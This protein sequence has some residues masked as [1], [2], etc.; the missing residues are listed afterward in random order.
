ML[1]EARREPSERAAL[2]F[3]Q[4]CGAGCFGHDRMLRRLGVLSW[5]ENEGFRPKTCHDRTLKPCTILSWQ[6]WGS[7]VR[8][9]RRRLRVFSRA[10]AR[11]NKRV[12]PPRPRKTPRRRAGRAASRPQNDGET[13]PGAVSRSPRPRFGPRA[14][15]AGKRFWGR[16]SGCVKMNGYGQGIV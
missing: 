9:T 16:L 3:C 15:L 7:G 4:R 10:G 1:Y 5:H 6:N 8:T 14:W 2:S 13:W 11:R 12:S